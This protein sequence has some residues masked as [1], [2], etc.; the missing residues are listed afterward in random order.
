MWKVMSLPLLAAVVA[1]FP[2]RGADPVGHVGYLAQG[3]S[4]AERTQ[5]YTTPQGSMLMP[6]SWFLHLEQ[7]TNHDLF[8]AAENIDRLRYLPEAPDK[9]HN[10]D[11]LPVGFTKQDTTKLR[12]DKADVPLLKAFFRPWGATED[13]LPA[14]EAWLGLNCSACHTGQVE[15]AGKRVR[16]DG[17]PALADVD[18]FI[19]SLS[20][21]VE[22]TLL[23]K[24]KFERFAHKVLGGQNSPAG[25]D[26]L[27]R[28]VTDYAA[29]LAAYRDRSTPQFAH[30]YG[31]TDAFGSI[32]NEVFGT[33]LGI[34][35]NYR[36]TDAPVS[37]PDLW[38]TPK[39]DWVQWNGSVANPF[40][41]NVGE[42]LGVYGHV[43]ATTPG[44]TGFKSTALGA[45]LFLLEQLVDKLAP[46]K[47]DEAVLGKL[48]PKAAA[49]G[50]RLYAQV[51]ADCH[52]TPLPVPNGPPEYPMTAPNALG[53]RFIRTHMTGLADIGTDPKM[54]MNFATRKAL[55]GVLGQAGVAQDPIPAPVLLSL[56]VNQVVTRQFVELNLTPEQQQ[57]Y[58]GFRT[59]GAPP[60]LLAYKAK[61]LAGVWATA[62]YLH[63]GSVPNLRE[64]LQPPAQRVRT[65]YVGSREYD[66]AAV[67]F[68]TART[69]GAY[70][71]NTALPGNA[72]GGH[73]YGTDLTDADKAD[74]LEYLKTL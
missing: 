17:A 44:P 43:E 48:N 30:G 68:K 63:N 73:H 56:F 37:Y 13:D 40:G 14:A 74:L 38:L 20:A 35:A 21:A 49:H 69:E 58:N 39:L 18:L 10:P 7:A 66:P 60:N 72:N 27:R 11:G 15:H 55:P 67:G 23:E 6:Y 51:C 52:P 59:G 36:P 33:A 64:L 54:A 34:P 41:R 57:A 3:W 4:A 8:R 53:K 45:N 29:A 16:V 32:M 50:A 46:P 70:L 12:A 65:F 26:S 24:A 1:G 28:R 61:P 25:R 5:F 31:R 2:L 47:W 42:V 71:F 9:A 62:P 19:R 22:A